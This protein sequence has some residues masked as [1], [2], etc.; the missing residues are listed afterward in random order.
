MW[1]ELPS[2]MNN[3]LPIFGRPS[4]M[5]KITSYQQ[6]TSQTEEDRV[7]LLTGAP[8][9]VQKLSSRACKDL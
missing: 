7:S 9:R 1:S 3:G 5:K 4:S 6:R 8:V 2:G